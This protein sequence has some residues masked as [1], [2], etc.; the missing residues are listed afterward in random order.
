MARSVLID[1]MA[2]AHEGVPYGALA[3]KSGPLSDAFMASRCVMGVGKFRASV[4]ELLEHTRLT[5]GDD[6]VLAVPQMVEDEQAR[7]DSILA[8]SKSKGNPKLS[9]AYNSP[10]YLYLVRRQSDGAVKIGIAINPI[11][12]FYKIKQQV[13]PDCIEQVLTIQVSDMGAEELTLHN[14]YASRVV[15]GDWFNLT[16]QDISD[17]SEAFGV[18]LKGQHKGN[19]SSL[20][21]A[22]RATR[23]GSGSGSESGVPRK[24]DVGETWRAAGWSGPEEFEFWWLQVVTNHPNKYRNAVAKTL[25]IELV[26]GGTFTREKFESGYAKLFES[27][28]KDWTEQG[29]KYSP[30]LYEIIENRLYEFAPEPAKSADQYETPEEREARIAR[31]EWAKNG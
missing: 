3:D 8:G 7:I 10:G 2:L 25:A 4:S 21:R 20:S 16:E 22:I 9:T 15:N 14:R 1:L 17:I 26:A 13:K 31:E 28:R 6:G 11:N 24:G 18:P 29:G 5:K 12:R 30:N 19:L 23:A 27:K